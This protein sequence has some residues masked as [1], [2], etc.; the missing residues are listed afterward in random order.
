MP[1]NKQKGGKKTSVIW[2]KEVNLKSSFLGSYFTYIFEYFLLEKKSI[3][4][5]VFGVFGGFMLKNK[6]PFGIFLGDDRL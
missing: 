4:A 3:L 1:S 6:N 2:R 5:E